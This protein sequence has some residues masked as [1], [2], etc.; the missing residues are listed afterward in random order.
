MPSTDAPV[1]IGSVVCITNGDRG[2]SEGARRRTLSTRGG[3]A[4]GP[5]HAAARTPRERSR[6]GARAAA[7]RTS[8]GGHFGK[9]PQHL[10]QSIRKHALHSV[11]T[12]HLIARSMAVDVSQTHFARVHCA[13]ERLGGD[14]TAVDGRLSQRQA[15]L[16]GLFGNRRR[17]IVTDH[18]VQRGDQHERLVQQGLDA[19]AVGLDAA[20]A[21]LLEGAHAVGQQL[22]RV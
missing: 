20:H 3:P 9:T 5:F 4:A 2:G 19:L 13:V 8:R 21:V 6:S 12:L 18:R 17:L 16:V 11:T 10:P 22:H 15:F 7:G 14:E 1:T